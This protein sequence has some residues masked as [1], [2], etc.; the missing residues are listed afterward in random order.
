MISRGFMVLM[1]ALAS[2]AVLAADDAWIVREDGI[3]PVK[4]GMT[5]PQLNAVLGQKFAMPAAKDDQSCFDVQ[6]AKHP[7]VSFMIEDGICHG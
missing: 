3:G 1:L 4:V 5:L 2:I 7:H 6:P